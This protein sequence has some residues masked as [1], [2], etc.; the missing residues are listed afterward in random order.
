M[1]LDLMSRS[2]AED[3]AM[4][5]REVSTPA[6][7]SKDV[8]QDRNRPQYFVTEG[9]GVPSKRRSSVELHCLTA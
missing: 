3:H 8:N 9:R 6:S 4:F 2:P 5:R 1:F 7:G